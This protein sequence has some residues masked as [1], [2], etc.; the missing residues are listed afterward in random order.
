MVQGADGRVTASASCLAPRPVTS[1]LLICAGIT[2][3]QTTAPTD[4]KR[5]GSASEPRANNKK[6]RAA[7]SGCWVS[8]SFLV[9]RLE[10]L[11]L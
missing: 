1:V 5:A 10:G 6:G 3:A 8:L 7:L 2:S 9:N 11:G 4:P